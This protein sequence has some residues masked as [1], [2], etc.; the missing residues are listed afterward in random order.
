MGA[1][2]GARLLSLNKPRWQ[3]VNVPRVSVICIV[4]NSMAYLPQTVASVLAQ[5]FRDFELII[6]D[7]GSSDHVAAWVSSLSDPRLRFVSQSNQGIPAARNTGLR[8]AAGEY[9]A[10][11]DGDDLW[12]ASKLA[13]QV[14]CLDA[15]PK[16]GLVYTHIDL[17]DAFGTSL[18]R[19]ECMNVEGNALASVLVSNFIGSGSAPMLR[20]RCFDELGPFH[21]DPAIAWCDDWDMWVRVATRYEFAVL[22]RPLTRYRLH[23]GGASTNY[24]PLVPLV[25]TIVERLYGSAPPRLQPLKRKT[26]GTFYLYLASRALEARN[27][28]DARDLF[29]EAFG[30]AVSLRWLRSGSRIALSMLAGRSARGVQRL[31][32]KLVKVSKSGSSAS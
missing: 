24:Q 18:G 19:S 21:T 32:T 28:A 26:Y 31:R 4:Y 12:D 8:H 25:P 23:S 27:Y 7:D 5:S 6:V 2:A 11:L 3:G 17:I 29:R 20:K 22:K 14:A 30:Y 15:R 10:F 9:V 16:V 1:H 13:Q